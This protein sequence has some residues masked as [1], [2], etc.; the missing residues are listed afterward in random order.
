MTPGGVTGTNCSRDD[1]P[2]GHTDKGS[3]SRGLQPAGKKG[4]NQGTIQ[5]NV[6]SASGAGRCN[7]RKG[8]PAQV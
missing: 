8:A 2:A 1:V 4:M 5:L 7:R 6:G 3:A